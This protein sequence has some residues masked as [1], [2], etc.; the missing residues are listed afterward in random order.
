MTQLRVAN[1]A[2]DWDG[3]LRFWSNAQGLATLA[4]EFVT[5]NH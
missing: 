3:A 1:L 5:A 4:T 2:R